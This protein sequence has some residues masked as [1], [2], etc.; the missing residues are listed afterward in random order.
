MVV[1]NTNQSGQ[2][3]LEGVSV[4]RTSETSGAGADLTLSTPTGKVRQFLYMTVKYSANATVTVT[5]TLNS[6]AGAGY[7]YLL[8]SVGTGGGTTHTFTPSGTFILLDDDTID[9][10]APLVTAETS[11]IA[12]YTRILP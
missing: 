10:K 1:L 12:I 11:N 8:D 3:R 5:T 6:G 9:V 4:T 7:D 2:V